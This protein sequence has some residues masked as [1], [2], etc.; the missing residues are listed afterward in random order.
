MGSLDI[1]TYT[2]QFPDHADVSSLNNLKEIGGEVKTLLDNDS[3]LQGIYAPRR[4]SH[5]QNGFEIDR[6]KRNIHWKKTRSSEVIPQS[7]IRGIDVQAI[8]FTALKSFSV[9]NNDICRLNEWVLFQDNNSNHNSLRV[10][11]AIEILLIPGTVAEMEQRPNN[12]LIS[13]YSTASISQTYGMPELVESGS[14][15]LVEYVVN[16]DIIAYI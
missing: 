16:F 11:Q 15:V 7:S 13:M 8:S 12:V 3:Y 1:K 4:T 5:H 2:N 6:S 9:Q 14:Y 10:G